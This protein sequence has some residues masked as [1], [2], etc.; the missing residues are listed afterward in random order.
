MYKVRTESK[1]ASVESPWKTGVWIGVT[2]RSGESLIGSDQGI[3]RT[4]TVRRKAEHE[5]WSAE[6][7]HGVRGTPARPNPNKPGPHIP[8]RINIPDVTIDGKYVH[9]HRL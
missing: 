9:H 8:V 4:W 6:A 5:R 7:V 1:V 2:A 3:T